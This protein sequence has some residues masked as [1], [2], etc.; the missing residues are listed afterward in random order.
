M[1]GF[2]FEVQ[3][4]LL[5]ETLPRMDIAVFVG[6]AAS[7]P[8]HTPVPVEDIAHFTAIFGADLALAWDAQQGTPVTA[9]LAPTVQA[10]FRN[11]GRRCWVVRVAGQAARTNV[12]PIPGL[13]MA[14]FDKTGQADITPALA[15]ARS[16]GSW[17]DGLHVSATLRTR[18]VTV[19]Q[20]LSDGL[21]ADLLLTSPRDIAVGDL[22]R[23]TMPVEG[24]VLVLAVETVKSAASLTL[25][26]PL[27][28]GTV[29]VKGSRALWFRTSLPTNSS[30][31]SV[32]AYLFT[33]TL[34]A[35]P[36]VPHSP[37]VAE[38]VTGT[39]HDFESDPVPV[40]H[41]PDW[42]RVRTD[43]PFT[44]ELALAPEAAP[45]PG[46][47][48]R[49]DVGA[50]QLWFSVQDIESSAVQ[51]SPPETNVRLTGQGLWVVPRPPEPLPRHIGQSDILTFDL[52]VRQ[53]SE[54]ATPLRDLG[55]AP[56]HPRFWAALPTDKKFYEDMVAQADVGRA[57]L[58]FETERLELGQPQAGTRFPLAGGGS[59]TVLYFPIGMPFV[60]TYYLGPIDVP[61]TP[62]ERDGLAQ[63][64]ASLFLD[65]ALVEFST[66]TLMAQ[67]DFLQYLSP[68]PR[69]LQG[70]HAALAIAEATLIAVPDAVHRGWCQTSPD[71]LPLP[72]VSAPLPR[73]EWWH[74]LACSPPPV[75]P[76]VREPQWGNFLN[77]DIRIIPAP[78]LYTPTDPDATGTFTLAWA[79]G[80]A[81]AI[82]VLEEATRPNF[83][84][85]KALYQ[86]PESRLTLYGRSPG[87][88][89]YRVRTLVDGATSDW[90]NGIGVRV[91][92]AGRWQL[93]TVQDYTSDTLLAV[94]RALIRLCAARGDLLAVLALPEH[95]REQEA[96]TH[97][98]ILKASNA[99]S[100]QVGTSVFPPLNAGEASAFS[101][102]AVYHPWMVSQQEVSQQDFRSIPPDGAACGVLAQRALAR[103]AWIA[104]ANEVF[105]GAVALMPPM[106]RQRWTEIQ[107][108]QINLVR[109]EP[110]GFVV[111][112]ADTLSNDPDL[113][114]INVRRL[115]ILLRRL[116]LRLGATYVFEPNDD[117]FRRLV[118]RGFEALLDDMFGRGAFAGAT[119]A[120]SFQVVTSQA[121]NTPES[122]DQGR[123]IVELKVAPSLPLTFLTVR[124]VQTGDRTFI[125]EGR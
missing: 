113:R 29:R 14:A 12:F 4:P 63:F 119:P 44:L 104:P 107:E 98:E 43:T 74:F 120:T 124:L 69:R 80:Q 53:G 3:A 62:L 116:A 46:S 17:S 28:S 101:Y 92:V 22:L 66:T 54:S 97:I 83:S 112:S 81:E 111:L 99:P 123:F 9:Y 91:S 34:T 72:E 61:G 35:H 50:E 96:I 16:E 85:A 106:L 25:S 59:D 64:A 23:V 38:S 42:S 73:P 55:Y 87:T 30:P 65:P 84:D 121:L 78:M 108:V 88:Y 79:P 27:E 32:Q 11:G 24:Y 117:A 56:Q 2:R 110:R 18:P 109:Q 33:G 19:S 71:P 52:W 105:S 67:A 86:G 37:Q 103:G 100:L 15:Q 10:F 77:C 115:L 49:I 95:Y 93:R 36:S 26:P 45:S 1:P 8:L 39:A 82:S 21:G 31:G 57:E 70:I 7:G 114:P 6:F 41:P 47:L 13:A 48:V 102:A 20:L 58:A 5:R 94:Q 60:P 40:L 90:S 51:G 75:I 122:V 76:L 89:Y 125:T 118:Q 68:T